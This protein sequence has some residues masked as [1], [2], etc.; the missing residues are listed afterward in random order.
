MS[1]PVENIEDPIIKES[2]S[3]EVPPVIT[4]AGKGTIFTNI[5]DLYQNNPEFKSRY[6]ALIQTYQKGVTDLLAEFSK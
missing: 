5:N 3:S 6:D 2:D 1:D 4:T